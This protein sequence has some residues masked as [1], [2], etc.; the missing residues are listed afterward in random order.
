MEQIERLGAL[1]HIREVAADQLMGPTPAEVERTER[2]GALSH[3]REAAADQLMGPT[4]AEVERL[5]ALSSCPPD[6]KP[7]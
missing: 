1:S 2:L 4:P 6:L 3:I 7:P 5:K